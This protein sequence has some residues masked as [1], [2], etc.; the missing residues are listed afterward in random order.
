[1]NSHWYQICLEFVQ[2]DMFDM[3]IKPS[4]PYWCLYKHMKWETAKVRDYRFSCIDQFEQAGP[5]YF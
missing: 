3:K 4:L 1:M 5:C 2:A